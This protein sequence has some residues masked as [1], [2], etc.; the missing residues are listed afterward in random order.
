MLKVIDV[1]TTLDDVEEYAECNICTNARAAME[2]GSPLIT[3]VAVW[4]I[5]IDLNVVQNSISTPVLINDVDK[6]LLSTLSRSIAESIQFPL[7]TCY[8]HGLGCV[9][10]AMT[11]AFKYEY[12][13]NKSAPVNLYC[14]SAQ[15][16]STGKSGVN[17]YLS[18]PIVKAFKEINEENSTERKM[19]QREIKNITKKLEGTKELKDTEE[20]ELFDRLERANESLDAIPLW[21]PIVTD[22]TIEAAEELAGQQGGMFNIVSAEAEA[23][24]VILG[25]VYGDESGG[26][27]ANYGLLLKAWDGEYSHSV[28]ITRSGYNGYVRAS[29]SV[30]AQNESVESILAAAASGRGLAERFLLLVEDSLLGTRDHHSQK[31]VSYSLVKKYEQLIANIIK[32]DEV[33]LKFSESSKRELAKWRQK[34]EP[35]LRDGGRYSH[36]LLTGFIGKADKQIMKIASVLHC[37]DHWQNQA[38][39]TSE[40]KDAYI[41]RA[42]YIFEQLA[43]TYISAADSMG[44]VG[45]KSELLKIAEHLQ[46]LSDKGKNKV[47]FSQLYNS[48]KN[49]KPFKGSRN[50]AKKI[51]EELVPKLEDY[52]YCVSDSKSVYINPRLK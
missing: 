10:S 25:A 32:E 24:S 20:M 50:L 52:N 14:V 18:D 37:V 22:L 33:V 23:I 40:V 47:S 43:Q 8:F 45:E 31:K 41:F 39:R 4:G 36:N 27:K 42:I 15:P 16:P 49:I 26:K 21:A 30:I 6:D 28:R 1:N 34:I 2:L 46:K 35:E 12:R 11:K 17:D 29:I 19:L 7:N 44:Y 3:S 9:A 5:P 13:E 48:L 38:S 51:R